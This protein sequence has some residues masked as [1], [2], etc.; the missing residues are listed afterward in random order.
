MADLSTQ[1]GYQVAD[2][3]TSSGNFVHLKLF[4]NSVFQNYQM[5]KLDN[6]PY[7]QV[8]LDPFVTI[9]EVHFQHILPFPHLYPFYG[10]LW[11]F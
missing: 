8:L 2:L 9:F 4:E 11:S 10:N 3:S 5:M 6:I 7:L 1:N